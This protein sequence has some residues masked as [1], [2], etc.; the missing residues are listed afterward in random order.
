MQTNTGHQKLVMMTWAGPSVYGSLGGGG[1]QVAPGCGALDDA[2]L[3]NK[4]QNKQRSTINKQENHL[5]NLKTH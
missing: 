3:T 1:T 4:P 5:R 2:R